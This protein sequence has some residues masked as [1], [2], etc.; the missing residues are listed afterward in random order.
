MN[1]FQITDM[2]EKIAIDKPSI[3]V[4]SWILL[5]AIVFAQFLGSGFDNKKHHKSSFEMWYGFW[6]FA[7]T[8]AFDI[9]IVIYASFFQSKEAKAIEKV[10]RSVSLIKSTNYSQLDGMNEMDAL[11]DLGFNDPYVPGNIG[12]EPAAAAAAGAAIIEDGGEDYIDGHKMTPADYARE[13]ALTRSLINKWIWTLPTFFLA[14]CKIS[15]D[16]NDAYSWHLIFLP[17]YIYLTILLV[18]AVAVKNLFMQAQRD[19]DRKDRAEIRALAK[20]REAVKE[21]IKESEDF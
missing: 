4:V 18:V 8:Y 7:P 19:I 13:S 21:Q 15:F 1:T 16:K 5:Q 3:V 17:L 20:I 14:S 6:I 10:Y 12:E 9:G 2:F 11:G